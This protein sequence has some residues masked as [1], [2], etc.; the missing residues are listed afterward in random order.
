MTQVPRHQFLNLYFVRFVSV[1]VVACQSDVVLIAASTLRNRNDVIEFHFIV[2]QMLIT[3]LASI[4]VATDNPH[5]YAKRNVPS[6]PPRL[7]SFGESFCRK[8]NRAYVSK[9]GTLHFGDWGRNIFRI[10]SRVELLNID[11]KI[12]SRCRI[13]SLAV[14]EASLLQTLL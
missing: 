12:S 14:S 8:D 11:L 10:L 13:E 5:L 2:A 6:C 3:V 7:L 9:D 1:A 4:V